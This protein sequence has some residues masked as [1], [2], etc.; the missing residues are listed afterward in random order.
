MKKIVP[1]MVKKIWGYEKW[2]HSPLKLNQSQTSDG[3][4]I[5][6]GPL[7]KIIKTKQPLSVQVHPDGKL[8]RELEGEANGKNECWFI[9]ESNLDS[10]FVVDIKSYNQKEIL[11]H[12]KANKFEDLLVKI[13]PQ[14]NDV[15]NVPAGMIHSVGQNSKILEIQEPSDITYRFFDFNRLE[16]GKPRP[17]HIEKSLQCLKKQSYHLPLFNHDPITY[18]FLNYVVRIFENKTYIATQE[19]IVI[20]LL[21]EEGFIFEK[22]EEVTFKKFAVIE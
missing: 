16:N 6:Q 4:F 5:T 13:V 14:V 22:G 9:L 21:N 20:D 2:L 15:I 17:L 1:I 18:P 10:E 7:I 3:K 19:S 12:I 11:T 8:A